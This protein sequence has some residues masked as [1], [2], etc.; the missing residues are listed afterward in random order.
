MLKVMSMQ[1]QH[2]VGLQAVQHHAYNPNLW[3]STE[4]LA[5]KCALSPQSCFVVCENAQVVAYIFAHPWSYLNIPKLNVAI[6]QLAQPTELLYIH[7][8]AVHPQW[9]GRGL[10]KLLLAAVN[11]AANTMT[12]T[13][14]ALV[15]VQEAMPFWQSLGFRVHTASHTQLKDSLRVY[16]QH[17]VYMVKLHS[18]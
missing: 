15:A 1:T 12:L 3:E 4:A 13:N 11:Q 8:L 9:H 6:T 16:G 10:A 14:M 7:D 18:H 5:A 17:A 2:F